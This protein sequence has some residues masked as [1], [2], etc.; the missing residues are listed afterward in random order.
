MG[1]YKSIFNIKSSEERPPA[2]TVIEERE[3]D[4]YLKYN[5]ADRLDLISYRVYNDPQYWWIILAA[6]GYEIEFDIEE[7]K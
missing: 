7:F 4:Y 1:R 5:A 3:T 6:N 2:V